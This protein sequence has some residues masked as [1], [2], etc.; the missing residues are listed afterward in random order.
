[1][2]N[3]PNAGKTVSEILSDKKGGIRQAPL[4]AGSP[5]WDD[6]GGMIWEEVVQRAA[7]DEPGFRTIRKLLSDRR[8]NK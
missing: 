6:I 2:A 3:N 1:M 4:E 5:S 7:A 8:F